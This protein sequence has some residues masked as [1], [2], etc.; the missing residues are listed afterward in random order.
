MLRL[1]AMGGPVMYAIILC[2][3]VA[4]AV[5]IEKIVQLILIPTKSEPLMRSIKAALSHGRAIEA[6]QIARSS[7]GPIAALARAAVSRYGHPRAEISEALERAGREEIR[8]LE[9][10][11]NV[12]DAIVTLAPLLGLLGTVTG[13]I[14]SFRVL[15]AMAGLTEPAQL[16][17]G[18]AEALI[19]TA[20][21]L[22]VAAPTVAAHA[23]LTSIVDRRIAEM[24]NRAADLLNL[25]S[26]SGGG[27]DDNR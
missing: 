13:L 3:V 21:G 4:L 2:S 17:G 9:G 20:A 23:Y 5:T 27:G 16:S 10:K 12:L 6:L 22:I 15:S 26:G 11:L 24:E 1:I 14:R 8:I 25:T 18:I 19:T 7:R